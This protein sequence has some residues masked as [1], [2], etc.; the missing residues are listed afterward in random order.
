MG[1]GL[2]V[3][4][5]RALVALLG[6]SAPSGAHE[7]ERQPT[8]ENPFTAL[9]ERHEAESIDPDTPLWQVGRSAPEAEEAEGVGGQ[10]QPGRSM[11]AELE[12]LSEMR[13]DGTL[14]E[15]EFNAAKKKLLEGA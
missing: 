4:L 8:T 15:D 13:R 2:V 9:R 3:I 14:S 1:L 10:A 12:R 7:N 5:I 6:K 11:V